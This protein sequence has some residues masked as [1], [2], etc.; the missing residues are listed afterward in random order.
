MRLTLSPFR[1]DHIRFGFS[2][3]RADP[4]PSRARPEN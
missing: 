1:T 2:E 3:E 4:S